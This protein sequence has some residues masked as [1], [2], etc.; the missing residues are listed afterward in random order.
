M[1]SSEVCQSGTGSFSFLFHQEDR[2]NKPKEYS[3]QLKV[4][5][6]LKIFNIDV[7]YK[8]N[9]ILRLRYQKG[10]TG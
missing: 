1:P 9:P 8:N 3:K 5:T 6:L 2:K 4:Y 10:S 7:F